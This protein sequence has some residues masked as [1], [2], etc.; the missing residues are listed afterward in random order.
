MA[1]KL[2]VHCINDFNTNV[3]RVS[4]CLELARYHDAV[5]DATITL[6][7]IDGLIHGDE[8]D[9]WD[10]IKNPEDLQMLVSFHLVYYI[11]M[12]NLY[13]DLYCKQ[14]LDYFS[15]SPDS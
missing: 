2:R 3:T 6:R 13:I 11:Y 8:S 7:E 4:S 9:C 15:S 14:E 1:D 10:P 5:V 12:V